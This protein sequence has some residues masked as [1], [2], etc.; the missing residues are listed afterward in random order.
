MTPLAKMITSGSRLK[1]LRAEHR[2]EAPEAGNH[3]ID[4]KE[5]VVHA[6]ELL[7]FGQVVGGR[8]HDLPC[9]DDGLAKE[10]GNLLSAHALNQISE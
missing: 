4:H 3:L 1:A 5:D 2:T 7:D 6:T 8:R 9:P 10:R